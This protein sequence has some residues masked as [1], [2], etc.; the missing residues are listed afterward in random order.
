MSAGAGHNA[1]LIG[2]DIG[3]SGVDAC[4]FLPDG[5]LLATTTAPLTTYYPRPGWAEQ[6]P[7][8]WVAA[9][10]EALRQMRQQLGSTPP[11][12]IG[13]TGQCPS[14]TLIDEHGGALAT[15]LI[16]QDNRA[17]EEARR[18]AELLGAE[19]V[20]ARTGLE[21]SHF[22]LAPRL[23]WLADRYSGLRRAR[24][25]LAQPRDL[26]GL[27]LTGMLAT[28]ATH[29]GCTGLYDLQRDEWTADWIRQLGLDW[30]DLPPIRRPTTLLGGLT[31]AAAALTGFPAGLPIC[32]GAADNFCADL[33]MGATAPGVLGDTSG[34]S[35]CL[36]LSITVPDPAPALSLY[37]HF[38]PDLIYA[39]V[40]LNATGA[41]LAWAAALLAGGDLVQLEA[42]AST[43]P[44]DCAAPLLLPYLGEGDRAN[45]GAR[46]AWHDL[47]LRHSPAQMA[48]SVYE[49]LTFALRELVDG[50]RAAGHPITEARLAGGG[51]RSAFW[52]G[53][54]ADV[55]RLPVRQ[56][57]VADASALG[58][59]MLAGVAVGVYPD[60]PAAQHAATRFEPARTPDPKNAEVYQQL[61]ERWRVV[62]EA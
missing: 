43:A 10:V 22:L 25:R 28:D 9:A 30:L 26:V 33:A 13:L 62:R 47:G 11:A 49:G 51:S 5:T 36:D 55:W 57:I 31:A 56:A 27:H 29:A 17:T 6:D 48:R 46:G 50:F 52:S 45:A 4:A 34:T 20:R 12:A 8:A 2:L 19:A 59:A 14:C 60:L 18:I 40:G 21:P 16:F 53:L 37:R 7:A 38:L 24:P 23:L 3:A 1:P 15:G 44:P 41:V 54:K 42:M 58:A 39:N 32:L 35:T 61:Y